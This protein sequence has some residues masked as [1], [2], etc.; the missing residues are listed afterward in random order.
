VLHGIFDALEILRPAKIR[1]Y[2][3]QKLAPQ[4][5][6]TFYQPDYFRSVLSRF[7][8]SAKKLIDIG[9]KQRQI[10]DELSYLT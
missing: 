8:R 10:I 9:W 2:Q 6:I 7:Y 1:A 3:S 4:F 5:W